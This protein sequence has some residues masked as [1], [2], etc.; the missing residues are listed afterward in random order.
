MMKQIVEKAIYGG[1]GML[2]VS[3][4]DTTYN[5][6]SCIPRIELI[7]ETERIERLGRGEIIRRKYAEIVLTFH[8]GKPEICV[9][10]KSVD[11]F[12]VLMSIVRKDGKTEMMNFPRCRLVSALDLVDGGTCTFEIEC[13]DETMAKLR[14][15]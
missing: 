6:A 4:G 14:R 9:P 3:S 11:G 12:G 5:V 7:H 13:S 8:A 2:Y 10:L 1:N 15:M